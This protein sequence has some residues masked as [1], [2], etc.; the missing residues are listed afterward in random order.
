M[1]QIIQMIQVTQMIE[2]L[3]WLPGVPEQMPSPDQS[4]ILLHMENTDIVSAGSGDVL[5]KGLR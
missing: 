1:F 3:R 5:I 2:R 4:H